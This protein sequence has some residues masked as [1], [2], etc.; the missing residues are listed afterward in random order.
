MRI[1]E[2]IEKTG[3]SRQTIHYYIREGLLP[4]PKKTSRNQ[5]QYNQ[6]HIDRIQLIKE[7]HEQFFLPL[8]TIKKIL[9]KQK[10]DSNGGSILKTKTEYFK[11][12]DQFLPKEIH[13][14][15]EFLRITGIS[16]DR[17][18]DFEKWEIIEPNIVDGQKVYTH[19]DLTIGRVIGKMRKLGISYEKGFRREGLRD[20]RDMFH[21]I[22]SKMGDEYDFGVRNKVP[23]DK[24][25]ELGEIY[26]EVMAVFFYH[27]CHRLAKEE[28]DQR[29][30]IIKSEQE[31]E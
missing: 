18:L 31:K 26:I 30:N 24:L 21:S 27:L 20:F 19:H 23:V 8:A 17:L 1:K 7:L 5:A 11:P 25:Y 14:E 6:V 4:R 10:K 3:T 9:R 29:L 15:T 12:L 13:G 16:P 22:V 2:L 28:F